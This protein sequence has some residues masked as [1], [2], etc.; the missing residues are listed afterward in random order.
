M[1][2]ED[3]KT[4][5]K[6]AQNLPYILTP[7]F[8]EGKTVSLADILLVLVE[9]IRIVILTPVAFSLLAIMYVLFIAEP[10][11]VSTSTLLP[12]GSDDVMSEMRGL[13][14]QFG[15]SVPGGIDEADFSSR[16][17][18]IE[19]LESRTL[20]N[21]MLNKTFETNK[22]GA[23]KSLQEIL[24]FDYDEA[25]YG[26]DTLRDMAVTKLLEDVIK[27]SKSK[28]SPLLT[29]EVYGFEAAFV[30]KLNKAI[31]DELDHLQKKFKLK[32]TN[33][34]RLFI[35]ERTQS[36]KSELETAEEKL[37]DFRDRNRQ[38]QHS[39]ALLLEQDRLSREIQVQIGVFTTLKQ[40]LE[41]A[42]IETVQKET[43]IQILDNPSV[44][45]YPDRPRKTLFV[46]FSCFVGG[47][48]GL[49]LSFFRNAFTVMS[50]QE[51]A[52]IVRVRDIILPGNKKQ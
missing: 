18:Y 12:S 28:K 10:V 51:K 11:Y 45:L 31:I 41:M 15:F 34:K 42:K 19:I 39:P 47:L 32:R 24:T 33:E 8:E 44:P 17:M 30:A 7:A 50:D 26:Q 36:V 27:V 2:E 29:L 16:E 3:N 49:L 5:K 46:I 4:D 52:K 9:N 1:T 35:E 21:S 48:F 25:Q 43:L 14:S 37:K 23:H 20:A 40:Q 13:A 6:E 38:I 22:Y